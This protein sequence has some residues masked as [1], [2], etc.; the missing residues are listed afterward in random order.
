MRRPIMRSMLAANSPSSTVAARGPRMH[1][2]ALDGLR[3]VAILLVFMNHLLLAL[4]PANRIDSRIRALGLTGWTGVDLFFVLS[5][6]LI[7]GI[8]LDTKGRTHWWRNFFVRRALRIMPLYYGALALLFFG[9]P[10]TALAHRPAVALL[11]DHQ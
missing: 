11:L 7:T 5:G 6:F 1:I 4:V 3:G 9:L 2:P 8:L 10:L